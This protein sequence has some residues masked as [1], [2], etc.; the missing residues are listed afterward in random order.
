[1]NGLIRFSLGNP[2]A[3]TVLALTIVLAGAVALAMIPADILPVYR[4]PAVQI[5]TFYGG[6]ATGAS[7]VVPKTYVERVG[8]DGFKRHPVGLGPYRFVRSDPGVEM[9]LEANERY[10]RKV[11]AIKTI[12]FKGV[13]ERPTRLAVA[14]GLRWILPSQEVDLLY[15][16]GNPTEVQ[17]PS[18]VEMAVSETEPGLRGDTA[19]GGGDKPATLESGVTVRVPLF[20][21]VGDRVRVDTRSG[22][23]VARA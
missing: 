2:R 4:S 18:A 19:S 16:D 12:V 8:D 3:I 20:V 1:M 15:I 14:D 9:V 23:Y 6:T 5:L 11:P 22:E 17:V 13:P 7:W 10:W 21:N